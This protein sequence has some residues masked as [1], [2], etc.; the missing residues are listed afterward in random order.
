M[1]RNINN[2]ET[3]DGDLILSSITNKILSSDND[4]LVYGIENNSGKFLKDVDGSGTYEFSNIILSDVDFNLNP[5]VVVV[6]DSNGDLTNS[7][8]STTTLNYLSNVTN[9]IQTQIDS[10]QNTINSSNRLDASFIGL[11][12][13]VSNTE[14]GYLSNVTSDI[15][16]QIDSKQDTI[17]YTNKL[18]ALY[19]GDYND[20]IEI[21]NVEFYTLK[22]N[23][24]NIYDQFLSIGGD[25]DGLQDD[26]TTINTALNNKQDILWTIDGNNVLYPATNGALNLVRNDNNTSFIEMGNTTYAQN[27]YIDIRDINYIDYGF[28]IIRNPSGNMDFIHRGSSNWKFNS[29][30]NANM[31]FQFSGDT[32][33]RLT[34]TG[35]DMY[36]SVYMSN[37]LSVTGNTTL[38]GSLTLTTKLDCSNI[39]T[40]VVDNTE[41]NY[42]NGVTSSIQTQLNNKQFELFDLSGTQVYVID[43]Y[44]TWKFLRRSPGAHNFYIGSD[45]TGSTGTATLYI[46]DPDYL[47]GFTIARNLNT[48][49]NHN[50]T[51]SNRGASS[52]LYI[53]AKDG[54]NLIHQI[55]NVDK[56]KITSSDITFYNNINAIN[57]NNASYFYSN[58]TFDGNVLIKNY[59]D[60]DSATTSSFIKNGGT[61]SSINLLVVRFTG[62][63]TIGV[64]NK[65]ITFRNSANSE[66]GAIKGNGSSSSISYATT[67]DMR[68]KENITLIDPITHYNLIK[69]NDNQVYNYNFIADGPEI[70]QVGFIAQYIKNIFNDENLAQGSCNGE[71]CT[72]ENAMSVDYGRMSVYLYSALK[73]AITEIE[74]LKTTVSIQQKL[75]NSLQ[76]D[77]SYLF[78]QMDILKNEINYIKDIM[79]L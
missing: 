39:G 12:G 76:T 37:N 67:S 4:G 27:N 50:T 33:I 22:N 68:L 17:S 74:T 13:N 44:A 40:G 42:L 32:N 73:A 53:N 77:N 57:V 9:D 49:G 10:K 43:D 30:D 66:L 60:V 36:K 8:I 78:D 61:G 70:N 45:V 65:F 41:F 2:Y 55:S 18:N 59:I 54:G 11:N 23:T 58:V 72:E 24:F 14:Y 15:Q 1:S 47:D 46:S 25:I 5:N 38:T 63:S 75:I 21:N 48:G 19:I 28:R 31:Y 56:F 69:N 62:L 71:E 34:A 3:I 79:N 35:C 26:I 52:T 51:I 64:N 7:T 16:T 29:Q 6:S 20:E